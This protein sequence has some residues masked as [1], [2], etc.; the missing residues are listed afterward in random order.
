MAKSF[1]PVEELLLYCRFCRKTL[2]AALERG[3]AGSGRTVDKNATFEYICSKCHRSHCYYGNDI[4]EATEVPEDAENA[5][6][7][8][9]TTETETER[10]EYKTSE[11]YLIGEVITHPSYETAGQI[12]GKEPGIPNRILVKF[13]KVITQF[14]EDIK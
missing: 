9:A 3:I 14:V 8:K 12:V 1:S 11:H 5:E 13:G 4:M 10:R 2:P 6:D 7:S